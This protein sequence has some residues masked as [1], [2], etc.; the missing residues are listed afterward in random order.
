MLEAELA[1]SGVLG[2]VLLALGEVA[3]VPLGL[4]AL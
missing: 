2:E 1:D 3:A 4:A